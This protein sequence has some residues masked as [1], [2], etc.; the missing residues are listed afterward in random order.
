MK[1][2][3]ALLIYNSHAGSIGKE[4]IEEKLQQCVPVL[5]PHIKEFRIIPTEKQEEATKLC[6]QYGEEMDVV[7]IL[8][9]DGTVHE[10][11]NGLVELEKRPLIGILP[12][13][14]CNDFSNELHIPQNLTKAAE[15]FLNQETKHVDVGRVNEEYFL[16]FCGLGLIAQTSQN[17]DNAEKSAM[18]KISYYL[19]ALRTLNDV[20]P[21]SYKITC[22][23]QVTEG[24]AALLLIANGRY[25]G[26]R[27]L[28]FKEISSNDGLFDVVIVKETSLAV[29]KELLL[30]KKELDSHINAD[31]DIV[32]K[33]ARAITVETKGREEA[34]TDGEVLT[35]TPLQ[36]SL[37]P[38]RLEFLWSSR[39]EK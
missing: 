23:D 30:N 7:F 3:K 39:P 26:T 34:D 5:S 17:I 37:L 4:T 25:L 18:G 27:E 33:Q 31:Q 35:R 32:Y 14:T 36:I 20:D 13:G 1:W 15:T 19:S 24:E 29:F 11:I 2:N 28:P 21:I 38:L 22:D 8:G 16:N 6:R 10:C 9:G 12:G